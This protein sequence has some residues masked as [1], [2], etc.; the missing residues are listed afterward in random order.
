MNARAN[1]SRHD[2]N[3]RGDALAGAGCSR[4]RDRSTRPCRITPERLRQ[5]LA[6]TDAYVTREDFSGYDPYDALK[7][8]IFKLP[9]LGS[10]HY[11]RLVMQQV[12]KRLPVNVRPLLGIKKTLSAV[13]LARMLEGY[14]H[15]FA[16]DPLRRDYY[17]EQIA[18]CLGRVEALRSRGY[19][20]D[21]WG[22]EFDWEPR[23]SAIPIPAG[24]PN[25]V[26]TGIVTNAL[27]ETSRLTGIEAAL[28]S[29][30]SAAD[31]VLGDLERTVARDGSF[32]WGYF[33]SDRQLVLNATMKGARLCAQVFS[34]TGDPELS[35][36]ARAAV[37]FVADHQ[38][39]DGAWPYSVGDARSWV[40]NFHTG[41]LLECLDA[42][43]RDT[44][45][46]SFRTVKTKGWRYYRES[47]LTREYVPKYFDC[48]I[49]PI[50]ATA[51]AQTISTLCTFGDV[52]GASRVALWVTAKMQRPDGGFVYQRHA[53][54][55]NRIPYMRWSIAP[56]FC[57]LARLL[58]AIDYSLHA[59]NQASEK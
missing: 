8:P 11:T 53:H 33:P 31:F 10:N 14:A 15:L 21:C 4:L 2:A 5:A 9:L 20:G 13:S 55:T 54:Y 27:F 22:Y 32:C 58:Y 18:T 7:S 28:D 51:C 44:K 36:A 34:R 23:Y 17:G 40:D 12:L 39:A 16:I 46:E 30:V 35:D 6:E 45:D 57:A 37:S 43:E 38:R 41:Y 52:L 56:M 29:C 3:R 50:D 19:S 59:E 24:V 1:R 48:R 42:Y 49:E 47:F 26:A 25:I